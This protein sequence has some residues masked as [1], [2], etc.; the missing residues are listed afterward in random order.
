MLGISYLL[1]FVEQV[2]NYNKSLYITKIRKES[3]FWD[4]Q[5][6]EKLVNF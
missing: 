2:V 5:E 1:I 6:V 3:L 4:L